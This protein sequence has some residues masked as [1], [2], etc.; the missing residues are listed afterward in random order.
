MSFRAVKG[1]G[2][3]SALEL[4]VKLL[5]S[6]FVLGGRGASQLP[7][8][9][10]GRGASQLSNFTNAREGVEQPAKHTSQSLGRGF[11]TQEVW[12]QQPTGQPDNCLEYRAIWSEQAQCAN[13][14]VLPARRSC[15]SM[16]AK[17]KAHGQGGGGG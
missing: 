10:G 2:G 1:K 7:G 16:H 4:G 15:Q 11:P 3:E 17:D 6:V 8:C 14:A 12:S 9:E 5:L 13:S